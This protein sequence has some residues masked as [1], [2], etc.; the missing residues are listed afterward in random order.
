[1]SEPQYVGIDYSHPGSTVNRDIEKDIRYGVISQNTIQP[2]VMSEIH[3]N[4]KDLSY[5][6]AVKEAKLSLIA[7]FAANKDRVVRELHIRQNFGER[8]LKA[9]FE[10]LLEVWRGVVKK[11]KPSEEDSDAL[12]EIVEQAFNDRYDH[13]GE[14][15][16]RWEEDGYILQDCLR[17]DVF[18]IKSPYYTYAQFCS[19]CVPGAGNLNNHFEWNPVLE[20]R[21]RAGNVLYERAAENAGFPKVFCL[22][23]DFFDND[24]APY[25]VFSVE[26][27]KRVLIIEEK[28]P[29]PKCNA[30]RVLPG[31]INCG[32]CN[33]SGYILERTKHE[34]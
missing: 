25:P 7:T 10:D 30:R 21:L 12:W 27:G 13:G 28:K 20:P 31:G 3:A 4:A 34:F 22:G 15:E 6:A 1:M 26:S 18:V 5:E 19:P 14:N 29:C 11:G 8:A 17:T 16:W 32:R 2:D 24:E 33:A 9:H 23:H